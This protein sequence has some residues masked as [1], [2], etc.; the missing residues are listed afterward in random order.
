MLIA[1][2]L[3]IYVSFITLKHSNATTSSPSGTCGGVLTARTAAD[4]VLNNGQ[5]ATINSGAFVDFTNNTISLVGTKQTANSRV[6]T[7]NS[8]SAGAVVSGTA[9]SVLMTPDPDLTVWT[10][11]KMLNRSMTV[12]PDPELSGA[13]QVTAN[14][15]SDLGVDLVFRVIP[16]N[17]GT[18][19]L[20]QGKNFG[21]TGMC[22][23]I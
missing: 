6:P 3:L 16:V 19:Y 22:Q 4:G 1:S 8:S 18:T 17:S 7:T 21:S 9:S 11:Q 15:L 14:T 20:I 5:V 10:Q 12:I 23:K 13:Y 2:A